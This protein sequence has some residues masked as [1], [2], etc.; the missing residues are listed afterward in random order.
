MLTEMTFNE[1]ICQRLKNVK[2]VSLRNSREKEDIYM[3]ICQGG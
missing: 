2:T 1:T 3:F